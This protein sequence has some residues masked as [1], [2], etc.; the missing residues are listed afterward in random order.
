MEGKGHTASS[1]M[2]RASVESGK[3]RRL[4]NEC[5][6]KD[7]MNGQRVSWM[8]L[9]AWDPSVTSAELVLQFMAGLDT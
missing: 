6:T 8:T 9:R 3:E 1:L 7:R 2:P 4:W 5:C